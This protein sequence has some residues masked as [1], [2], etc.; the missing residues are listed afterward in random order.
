M[1]KKKLKKRKSKN[2]AKNEKYPSL[3]PLR[4]VFNRRDLIDMDYI[5]DLPESAKK[6]L[7]GFISETVVT[8]FDHDGTKLYKTKKDKRKLYSENNKRNIDTYNV[9]KSS[10]KL[11][12]IN[13]VYEEI[14]G[15]R[16]TN[17]NNVEDALI[18]LIDSKRI[19]DDQ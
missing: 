16:S 3:N 4:Q 12:S 19:K 14:E 17:N 8:N 18:E 2:Y 15:N 1:A 10:G 6:W 7:N 11:V 13:N 5:K 9:A